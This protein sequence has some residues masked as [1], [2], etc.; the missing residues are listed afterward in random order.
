[1]PT[2]PG[3]LSSPH[4]LRYM[5]VKHQ[6]DRSVV[7]CNPTGA[8]EFECRKDVTRCNLAHL[9]PAAAS[10]K[11]TLSGQWAVLPFRHGLAYEASASD[12]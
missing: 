6:A 9:V 12:M 7:L 1:M 3:P 4:S 10:A 11:M 5:R 8:D 2:A